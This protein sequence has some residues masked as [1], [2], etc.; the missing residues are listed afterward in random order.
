MKPMLF[1]FAIS[2]ALCMSASVLGA[3]S[4]KYNTPDGTIM[5]NL[6]EGYYMNVEEPFSDGEAFVSEVGW[7]IEALK[8]GPNGELKSYTLNINAY[9]ADTSKGGT[10]NAFASSVDATI[11]YNQDKV[12]GSYTKTASGQPAWIGAG[13][14][15]IEGRYTAYIDL[16]KDK[17]K[18]IMIRSVPNSDSTQPPA[19]MTT[20]KFKE[21][22]ESI[23]IK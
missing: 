15:E 13:K 11:E 19:G 22:V 9:D 12:E 14:G 21:F 16:V 6:P 8:D 17:N 20:E 4:T 5:F 23:S 3:E 7:S 10:D 1:V 2:I 18:L